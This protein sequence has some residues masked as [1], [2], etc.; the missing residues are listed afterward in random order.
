MGTPPGR[1]AGTGGRASQPPSTTEPVMS[2]TTLF[3]LFTKD[4]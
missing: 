1:G 3:D 4:V 2:K